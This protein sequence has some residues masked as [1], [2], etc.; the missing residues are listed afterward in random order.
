M[1]DEGVIKF[2]CQW[3]KSAPLDE[4]WIQGSECLAG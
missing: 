4:A 2:N 3:T 1:N